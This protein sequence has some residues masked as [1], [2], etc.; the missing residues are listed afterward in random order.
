M[1]H[2]EC[3]ELNAEEICDGVIQY[4]LRC[5]QTGEPWQPSSD[6][7][8]RQIDFLLMTDAAFTREFGFEVWPDR[9]LHLAKPG[10]VLHEVLCKTPGTWNAFRVLS[11]HGPYSQTSPF[12]D[13]NLGSAPE[14]AVRHELLGM[15]GLRCVEPHPSIP[16]S[17]RMRADFRV[18]G[19]ND[20]CLYVEVAMV[21]EPSTEIERD[22]FVQYRIRLARKMK[23][24]GKAGLEP[25]TIWSNEV[26]AP[27]M[28]A[29]QM[30][31][32]RA[33]LGIP[34]RPPEPPKWYE[35]IA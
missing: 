4:A 24:Y 3:T 15:A 1:K 2:R 7:V 27:R 16:G 10:R 18:V 23:V 29:E 32:I 25:I 9:L 22:F 12:Q 6:R 28:L 13:V 14:R 35:E 17:A 8:S 21:Q 19:P 34:T 11:R 5:K 20:R 33:R 30:N 26:A 31:N